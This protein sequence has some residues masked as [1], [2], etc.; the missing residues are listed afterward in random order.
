MNDVAKAYAK[1]LT[2]GRIRDSNDLAVVHKKDRPLL[3]LIYLK[4]RRSQGIPLMK[5][6]EPQEGVDE[7][8]ETT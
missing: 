4:W 7:M 6:A 1:A 5:G 2:E 8:E 3:D